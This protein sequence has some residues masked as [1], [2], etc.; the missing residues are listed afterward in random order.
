MCGTE[1]A[2]F[3]DVKTPICIVIHVKS[4][5]KGIIIALSIKKF[6]IHDLDIGFF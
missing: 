4:T 1:I 6:H 3:A 5:K 2:G